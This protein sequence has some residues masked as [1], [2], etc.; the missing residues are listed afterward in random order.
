MV[1]GPEPCHVQPDMSTEAS[2]CGHASVLSLMDTRAPE[3]TCQYI[4]YESA[5]APGMSALNGCVPVIWAPS[6]G[7]Q[8]SICAPVEVSASAKSEGAT[9]SAS[10]MV[11][12]TSKT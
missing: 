12:E 4:S 7:H 10:S 3:P 6:V 9:P 11:N 2:L 1:Y 5:A 8:I